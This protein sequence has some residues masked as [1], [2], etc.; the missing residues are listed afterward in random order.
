VCRVSRR[1]SGSD[2]KALAAR[3]LPPFAKEVQSLPR[4]D[5]YAEAGHIVQLLRDRGSTVD[6]KEMVKLLQGDAEWQE[7][8]GLKRY[9]QGQKQVYSESKGV[10][11]KHARYLYSLKAPPDFNMGDQDKFA[12]ALQGKDF[13]IAPLLE[14]KGDPA[15]I[16]CADPAW[17]N[18]ARNLLTSAT[19]AS[20][21][22][23]KTRGN[24]LA[25]TM[26]LTDGEV[27]EGRD[28]QADGWLSSQWSVLTNMRVFSQAPPD[29]SK[30]A[31][32]AALV[33]KA[34]VAV[35]KMVRCGAVQILSEAERRFVETEMERVLTQ[36]DTKGSNQTKTTHA[37][38]RDRH[39]VLLS[40]GPTEGNKRAKVSAVA[41]PALAVAPPDPRSRHSSVAPSLE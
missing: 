31:A 4:F 18:L 19:T 11:V 35:L 12:D 32:A 25:A 8:V 1:L 30:H 21:K 14:M 29:F 28:A 34:Q 24:A 15:A 7:A 27:Q 17:L 26:L 40:G 13:E 9:K 39:G 5:A 6:E 41:P 20:S 16:V 33:C 3:D 36:T 22:K 2:P 38:T 37:N 23:K 10:H